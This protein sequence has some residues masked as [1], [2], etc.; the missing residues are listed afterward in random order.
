[1]EVF[2]REGMVWLDDEFRGPLH[3]QTSAGT[4]VRSCPSPEWMDGLPLPDD[5]IGLTLRAYV[6]ENRGFV[7]AITEGSAPEPGLDV[8]LVA[9]SLVDAAYRSAA[10]GGAP[11]ALG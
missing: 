9:H 3:V 7:D 10:S 4:E 2:C 8:A 6:E 11:L 1:V 5:E